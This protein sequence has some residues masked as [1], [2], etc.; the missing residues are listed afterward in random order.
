MLTQCASPLAMAQAIDTR[1]RQSAR[2]WQQAEQTQA[3][4][5]GHKASAGQAAIARTWME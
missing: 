1:D 5:Q 4:A 2:D 3:E